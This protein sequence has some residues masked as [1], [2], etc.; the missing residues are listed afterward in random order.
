[1]PGDVEGAPAGPGLPG[2]TTSFTMHA[3]AVATGVLAVAAPKVRASP[4]LKDLTA[5]TVV[6]ASGANCVFKVSSHT[7]AC[8]AAGGGT[9][10]SS[11]PPQALKS[12]RKAPEKA[13]LRNRL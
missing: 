11:P 6:F 9:G 1:M 10:E 3:S 13:A 12:E 2:P 7:R 5:V 4:F 8:C